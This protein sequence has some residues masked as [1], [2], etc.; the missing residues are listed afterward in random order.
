MLVLILEKSITAIL[1]AHDEMPH[2]YP[3]L[4]FFLRL[5]LLS[6]SL[7]AT[8]LAGLGFHASLQFLFNPP[9]PVII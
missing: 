9:I 1:F 4:Q 3:P 6:P 8:K 7:A 5:F 2:N